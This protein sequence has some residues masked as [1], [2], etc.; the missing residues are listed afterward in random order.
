MPEGSPAGYGWRMVPL[1]LLAAC[2]G[3]PPDRPADV[4]LVTLDTT[5]ADRVLHE[6]AATADTPVLD[7]LAARGAVFPQV[8]SPAPITLVSHATVL[9]GRDPPHHGVH[10][11]GTWRLGPDL[12]TL[13]ERFRDAG[14]RTGAFVGAAVLS[15]RYG[16]DRGFAHY[17]DAMDLDADP[18]LFGVGR[19]DC[20]AVTRAAEAWIAE[21]P[22]GA[23]TFAWVHF[24]DPH[25]PYA[26]PEPERSRYADHPYDGEVAHADRCLGELLAGWARAGHGEALLVAVTADHGESLGEHGEPS[27]SLFVYEATQRVSLV[28]AGPGVEAGR[29]EAVVG[30]V[31]LAP[32]LAS[33]AG[34]PPWGA[35]EGADL[36]PWVRGEGAPPPERPF[37]VESMVPRENYGWHALTGVRLGRWKLVVGVEPELYDLREDPGELHDLAARRP[38]VVARLEA[39]RR[40]LAEG[41]AAGDR[42][43]LDAE[44]RAA[45]AA[46]GYVWEEGAEAAPEGGGRDPRAMV[47][48]LALMD[49]AI[50]L[51]QA[52]R[53]DEAVAATR[54]VLALDPT[55]R[56][57]LTR[58]G[59]FLRRAGRLDEAAEAFARQAALAPRDPFARAQ[60]ALALL[61]L[62]RPEDARRELAEAEAEGVESIETHLVLAR[63]ALEAGR[64]DEARAALAAARPLLPA[65][66]GAE[67]AAG[68]GGPPVPDDQRAWDATVAAAVGAAAWEAG[69]FGVARE[70]YELAAIFA[71]RDPRPRF[72]LG[73]ALDRLGEAAAA[74][75]AWRA[76]LDLDPDFGPARRRLAGAA[77]NRPASGAPARPAAPR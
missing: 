19:R 7:G 27:H 46:L 4:L 50:A 52:G 49:R 39:E 66:W 68:G 23:R 29:R 63:A 58:L 76:A 53:L 35:A 70:A 44:T 3:G 65:S 56:T 31:D 67:A 75:A 54:R 71:P 38:E 61:D 47:G 14:W 17:D 9:T 55:N 60:H 32:T 34:L 69:A 48:V 21:Q 72:N 74:E 62:G 28:I 64:P 42:L 13:A 51:A 5:R 1:A 59:V 8:S 26:P 11:N 10:N 73:L 41:A 12:P 43:A 37:W 57:A 40:R 30:L 22:P 20:E 15:S 16:L 6:G 36:G 18:G 77:G 45:L 33:L 24:Y 25:A 2:A